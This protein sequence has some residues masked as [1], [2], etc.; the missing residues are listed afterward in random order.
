MAAA[1]ADLNRAQRQ[2]GNASADNPQIRAATAQLGKAELALLW[3]ELRAPARGVVVDLTIGKGTFAQA[4][5]PLM[6]FGSFDEIWVEAYLTEN[7][8]GRVKA[9]Q[10]AEITLDAY[11]GR[12]LRRCCQQHHCGRFRGPGRARRLA[13][14]AGRTGLDAELHSATPCASK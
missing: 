9:G 7:N 13:A 14:R 6:T 12:I 4:G 11:P 2:L 3:T 10:P 1:R 8:L 5:K